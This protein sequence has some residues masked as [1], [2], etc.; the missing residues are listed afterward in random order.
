M[1]QE[2]NEKLTIENA[3]EEVKELISTLEDLKG[4]AGLLEQAVEA[5][6]VTD[7]LIHEIKKDTSEKPVFTTDNAMDI[8]SVLAEISKQQRL[9]LGLDPLLCGKEIGEESIDI[10]KEV[11]KTHRLILTLMHKNN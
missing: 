9:N 1:E 2:S 5:V 6:K 7:D 10:L 3:P 8:L 11:N 4:K